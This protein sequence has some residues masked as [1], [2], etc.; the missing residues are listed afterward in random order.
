MSESGDK[1]S[2]WRTTSSY[3]STAVSIAMVIYVVGLL[4]MFLIKGKAVGDSFKE[5]F[6]FEIYLKDEAK[7]IEITQLK[8]RLGAE[9]FI[10]KVVFKDKEDALKEYQAAI[11][12]DENFTMTLGI[13]PLP[14]NIDVYFEAEYLQPDSIDNLAKE[15]YNDPIVK[16]LHYPK[17]LMFKVYSN[18]NNISLGL[19][20]VVGLLLIIAIGLITNTIRL[21]VYSQ[22]FIIKT[23][24]LVGASN[25]FIRKPFLSSSIVLGIF[26]GILAVFGLAGTLKI[27]Y[28]FWPEF[29]SDLENVKLDL[30]LYTAMII[31]SV[32]ITWFATQLAV[33]KFLRLK[34]DKL[35]Y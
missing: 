19:L 24:Q 14:Q 7:D 2:N 35:Y 6:A 22:R 4:G 1:Y 11:D 26:S 8:K 9:D 29:Q 31:V 33:G 12:P 13:N 16:E 21:R 18:V 28:D 30:L 27:I 25:W 17:D 10:K 20:A 32:L 15:L 23:M 5:K 3:I 34:T